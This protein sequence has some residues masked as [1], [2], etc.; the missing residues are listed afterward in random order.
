MCINIFRTTTGISLGVN[1]DPSHISD[2]EEDPHNNNDTWSDM[3]TRDFAYEM[4]ANDND[5]DAPKNSCKVFKML[6]DH[7]VVSEKEYAF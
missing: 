3:G 6:F 5:N 7:Y 2:L 4:M 1:D